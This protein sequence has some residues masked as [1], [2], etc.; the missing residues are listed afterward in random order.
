LDANLQPIERRDA[1]VALTAVLD[2]P[3]PL[4]RRALAETLA[5]EPAAPHCL[6]ATLANDQSDIAAIVLA[7]S[8]LLSDA[9]LIDAAAI[10]SGLAQSAIAMRVHLSA[11]VAA[12]LA[13]VG[14]RDALIALATNIDADLPEFSMRRML[15]RFG[16]DGEIREALRSRPD[17]P[18]TL[19]NDIVIATAA[20]LTD[21]VTRCNW[22]GRE[23]AERAAREARE[24][25]TVTI[26]ATS[27]AEGTLKLVAHLRES[28]TLTAGLILR[29]LLC[30]HTGLFEAALAEL[31][32]VALNRVV[33]LVREPAGAGFAALYRKAKLPA[34][35]LPAFR[36]ALAGAEEFGAVLDRADGAQL[37]LRMIE[38]VLSAC[39]A[40]NGGELDELMALLRRFEAEAARDEAR[41]MARACTAPTTQPIKL[42]GTTA[43]GPF[44]SVNPPQADEVV[45][46]VDYHLPANVNPRAAE[47]QA[48]ATL[49]ILTALEQWDGNPVHASAETISRNDGGEP[50]ISADGTTI[51]NGSTW[52]AVVCADPLAHPIGESGLGEETG[53][54]VDCATAADRGEIAAAAAVFA[55][56]G[57]QHVGD[58]WVSRRE[59]CEE[60]ADSSAA[61]AVVAGDFGQEA[62]EWLAS[63]SQEGENWVSAEIAVADGEN[64]EDVLD[65]FARFRS[66]LLAIGRPEAIA[67]AA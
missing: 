5:S 12:A 58:W 30:G 34:A 4:V 57:D 41:Q 29:A 42:A 11:P 62:G 17:L 9:E 45:E 36:A 1:E 54:A 65:D 63:L 8:P 66:K 38:R 53:A 49:A 19:C 61:I 15:D 47:I 14:E 13:E 52:V 2:D 31:T 26:A 32:G 7:R 55:D 24:H 28:R 22:I 18:A 35:L 27:S 59:Q 3:S 50:S 20:A 67:V 10:G 51:A 23:R 43:A 48:M 46:P 60:A 21:F 64:R 16:D 44:L 37:S 40:I 39:S 6:I 33:G 25:A 56:A